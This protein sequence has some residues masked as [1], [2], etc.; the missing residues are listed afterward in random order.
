VTS[1]DFALGIAC[2]LAGTAINSIGL[3]LQK[4]EVNKSGM[5]DDSNIAYFFKRPL[6]II[7]ILM[8]TLL[9]APFFFIGIDLI[10]IALAQPLATAGLLVFVAGAV[11]V[12]K[13]RVSRI[14]WVGIS[15]MIAA[16]FLV[17]AAGVAGEVTISIFFQDAFLPSVVVFVLV[18]AGLAVAGGL[19]VK[20][21]GKRAVQGFAI[22]VGTSYAVVSISGQLVTVGFDVAFLPSFEPL[23]WSLGITGL[24]GVVAGTVL[25]II[26]S[27]RAFQKAQAIHIIPISQ[28]INNVLPIVAGVYLF[29]QYIGILWLFIPGVVVLLVAVT[30]L[31]RFQR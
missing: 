31:A 19:L 8:Q 12:L 4:R 22:L 29:G 26:F 11:L 27:Q 14:E 9:F 25:G 6:W 24:I 21:V 20:L 13:E 28:S 2:V 23:G 17:S 5:K 1:I 18:I 10:G 16:I 30:L 15:L 7:G 3:I